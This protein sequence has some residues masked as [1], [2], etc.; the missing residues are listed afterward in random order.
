MTSKIEPA[1]I[2]AGG[3]QADIGRERSEGADRQHIAVRKFDHVEHAEEQ[4]EADG[5]QRIHHAEHQPV[6]DV[7]GEQAS[8]H[9]R[10]SAAMPGFGR[11][12]TSFRAIRKD[13]DGRDTPGHDGSLTGSLPHASA[14]RVYFCPG[15][16]R[17]P[18]AYSLS[19]HSTN[20]PSCTTYFVMT[21]TV[22]WP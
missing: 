11:A 1:R 20:L 19:S 4:R 8:I 14:P 6:H 16:L 17:L 10:V 21:G 22:F 13:V 2:D 12:S 15:S 9:V 3:V 7:L 5:H 18:A